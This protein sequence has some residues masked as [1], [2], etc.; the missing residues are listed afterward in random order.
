MRI[1]ASLRLA[2]GL[3]I[4]VGAVWVLPCSGSPAQM[5]GLVPDHSLSGPGG[6]KGQQGKSAC[7]WAPGGL[8]SGP[9][10][11]TASTYAC[12]RCHE[13]QERWV[14]RTLM[15]TASGIIN[16]T[17][18]LWGAQ[19]DAGPRYGA[20]AIAGLQP[21]PTPEAS[22]AL[23]DDLLRRRC[24][25]CHLGALRPGRP[26]GPEGGAPAGTECAACHIVDE[27]ER[28]APDQ[29]LPGKEDRP[30]ALRLTA[31]VPTS[32]C[33][34]CHRGNHA[35]ADYA[36]L[37][38]R[39]QS[40]SYN[41][42][43]TDP[44][45]V[46]QLYGHSYHFLLPDIH[47]ERGMHCIDCH[48]VEE[49]MGAGASHSQSQDQVSI[50]CTDC[51][52]LPGKMPHTRRVTSADRRALRAARANPHYDLQPGQ[53]VIVTSKGH[54]LTNT[55]E[56]PG[57]KFLLVSKVDGKMHPIPALAR[58]GP[59]KGPL[60]HRIP[61]HLN[62]LECATCHA[63]W[64]FQ[65]LGLHLLRLDAADYEPWTWLTQQDDPQVRQI[66][67]EELAKP[68][69]QRNLPRSC[70]YLT[71]QASPGLWLAGYSRRGWE[72]IILG[73]N[74]RGLV[75][76]IRPQYQYWVSRVDAGGRVLLD[77]VT[78]ATTA[79]RT[80][81]AW[82]PYTPHT[83]RRQTRACWDCHG[84]G[85]ALGLGQMLIR[86]KEAQPLP[87]TRP[88]VD[89]LGLGFELEQ[90]IDG[91]GRSLQ[92]TTRPGAAFL[93]RERLKRLAVGNPLYVKYLLEYYANKE[94][95]GDAAGFTAPKK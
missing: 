37:F 26:E 90:V 86:A 75:S 52:G 40:V 68:P 22:G 25:R 21:L 11:C 70:D 32:Q 28:I 3:G 85:R 12:G 27:S 34:H 48:P 44:D 92:T 87:L 64:T 18:F 95:Y 51:H 9:A 7:A 30:E 89:G 41:F 19:P 14:K 1:P 4:W 61:G 16:Q 94:A 72:G 54:L 33:L 80:A 82:N 43:A 47:Y 65:D 49:I 83:I 71:G 50:R 38:Q 93:D 53:R 6:P 8:L 20:A 79:G 5:P 39:D 10:D 67:R 76:A 23:V 46:P 24:L 56:E 63:A 60:D 15:A 45:L 17:R 31:A 62:H 91:E 88:A 69:E 59:R 78:P 55:R 29:K 36:G 58:E 73:V 2:I 57:G 13:E 74:Y 66:L 77:S 42:E 81:L 35:G 84:N